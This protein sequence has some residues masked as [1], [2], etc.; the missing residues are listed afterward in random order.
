MSNKLDPVE[1]TPKPM[2]RRMTWK[3]AVI[4]L[5][6]AAYF[7]SPFDLIP[8]ALLGPIGWLDDLGVL[9]WALKQ[10]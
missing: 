3:K 6:A 7:V 5:L 9:A 4:L 1:V 2:R 10:A 8:E